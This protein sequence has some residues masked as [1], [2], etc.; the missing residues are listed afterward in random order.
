MECFLMMDIY[1]FV[2]EFT[3]K[4]KGKHG[5]GFEIKNDADRSLNYALNCTLKKVTEDA[6][7]KFSFNTA[8]SSIMELVNELYKYKDGLINRE[9][10]AHAVEVLVIVLSPFA[11]HICEEM[12]EALG[13]DF[14]ISEVKWPEYDESA[15]ILKTVEIV[16]QINGK[17]RTKMDIPSDM[18]KDGMIELASRDETITA[19]TEG[20][21]IVKIVAVLGRFINIVVK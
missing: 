17:V 10:F 2:Y 13:H 4:F 7:G 18:S 3:D 12:W 11:P 16:I 5:F 21:E 1:R 8:I 14:S 19:L 6:G 20:R 9:L 15:L